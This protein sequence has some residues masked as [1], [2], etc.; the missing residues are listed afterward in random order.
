M[1]LAREIRTYT[2]DPP[3]VEDAAWPESSPEP[4]AHHGT[5][6]R[7]TAIQEL[8]LR[9]LLQAQSPPQGSG[10]VIRR[11]TGCRSPER[12]SADCHRCLRQVRGTHQTGIG[13]PGHPVA[14]LRS[15]TRATGPGDSQEEGAMGVNKPKNLRQGFDLHAGSQK[16]R[17]YNNINL[18]LYNA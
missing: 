13:V 2:F 1:V 11:S 3:L 7:V 17:V 10:R 6:S 9:P 5:P 16:L 12:R 18:K 14:G 8:R 15:P 4:D